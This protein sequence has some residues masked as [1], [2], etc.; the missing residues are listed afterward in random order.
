MKLG[1]EELKN[2]LAFLSI[3]KHIHLSLKFQFVF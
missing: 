2:F 3:E 1:Q